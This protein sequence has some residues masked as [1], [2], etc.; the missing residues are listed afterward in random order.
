MDEDIELRPAGF[1]VA[2]A[3]VDVGIAAHIHDEGNV[4]SQLFR[5][6]DDPIRHPLD[7][8]ESQLRAFTMHSLGDAPSYRT[9]RGETHDQRAFALQK[10]H[11]FWLPLL[12]TRIYIHHA[13]LP[14]S[15]LMMLVQPVPALQLCDRDLKLT[16]DAVHSVAASDGVEQASSGNHALIPEAARARLDDQTLAFHQ[17]VLGSPCCSIAPG[18]SRASRGGGRWN[19][20][21]RRRER[22]TRFGAAGARRRRFPADQ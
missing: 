15:Y 8:S 19:S 14:S 22:D 2:K 11:N 5:Q 7:V 20:K 18:C 9:V 12:P 6:R 21:S 3:L 10:P 1:K 17:G 13:A 16:R 4:R